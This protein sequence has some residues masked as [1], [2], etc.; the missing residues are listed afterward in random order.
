MHSRLKNIFFENALDEA[1]RIFDGA[2]K[3]F[4]EYDIVDS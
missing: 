4:A 2:L 3:T 1:S